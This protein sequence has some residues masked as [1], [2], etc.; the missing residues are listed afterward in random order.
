MNALVDIERGV[1]V[2]CDL[3]GLRANDETHAVA[4]FAGHIKPVFPT[5]DEI[6]GPLGFDD[7]LQ[8]SNGGQRGAAKRVA[9][10]VNN[11]VVGNQKFVAK[12][13]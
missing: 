3:A 8:A 4:D 10:K 5:G 13:R 2:K 7:L 9:V 6:G 12:G 1:V 11:R